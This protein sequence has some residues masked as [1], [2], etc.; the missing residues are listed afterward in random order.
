LNI[1]S[2]PNTNLV[3]AEKN[4]CVFASLFMGKED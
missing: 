1:L 4:A 2:S 3:E